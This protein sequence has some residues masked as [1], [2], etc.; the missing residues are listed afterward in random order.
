MSD[1]TI[2]QPII[3]YSDYNTRRKMMRADK[4][5]NECY[6]KFM[7]M[8]NDPEVPET[9]L[10]GSISDNSEFK[11]DYAKN[12]YLDFLLE[13][14]KYAVDNNLSKRGPNY[15]SEFEEFMR[16]FNKRLEDFDI[17]DE[18]SP[19]S[20]GSGTTTRPIVNNLG[21]V[22]NTS[23]S[24]IEGLKFDYGFCVKDSY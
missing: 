22:V 23:M 20:Y 3:R 6:H 24:N 2:P 19:G 12:N 1:Y 18:N 15:H 16:T 9:N 13:R 14:C 4:I 7:E 10:S 11:F 5:Y 17:P 21:N 8:Q